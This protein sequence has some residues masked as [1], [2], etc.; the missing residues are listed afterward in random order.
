MTT[1]ERQF[2]SDGA[3]SIKQGSV[4]SNP[5]SELLRRSCVTSRAFTLIEL[6]VVIA[7][8]AILAGLLLPALSKAKLMAKQAKCMSN[9]RQ[10]G[11]GILLYAPDHNGRLPQYNLNNKPTGD[12]LFQNCRYYLWGGKRTYNDPTGN[13]FRERLL[14]PYMGEFIAECPLDKGYRPGSGL[15]PGFFNN[16]RFYELYGSSYAYQAAIL[17]LKGTSKSF[18]YSA[19]EILW[20]QRTENI[21]QPTSLVMAGDFT[22]S[23]AE[24]F[25]GGKIKHYS[26]MQMHH[27]TNYTAN[28]L[29]VDGHLHTEK[30][31][32]E[33]NHLRNAKYSIVR[34]DYF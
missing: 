28:L 2:S 23:Y 9:L 8:I 4:R 14:T 1:D 30:L 20:N 3:A 6:L 13:S 7:I 5:E 31:Q 17:D 25:T 27:P 11:L 22:V 33:P 12:S 21:V 19:T 18:E 24:Y 32:P 16:K 26:Y 29:F 34:T 10:I 15:D